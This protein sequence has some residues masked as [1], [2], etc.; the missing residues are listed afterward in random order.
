MRECICGDLFHWCSQCWSHHCCA[1]TQ[2]KVSE[3]FRLDSFAFSFRFLSYFFFLHSFSHECDKFPIC[4]GTLKREKNVS[5]VP[6]LWV[7]LFFH[8]I[9]I[10]INDST[11]RALNTGFSSWNKSITVINCHHSFLSL[12]VK[13]FQHVQNALD[14]AWT[15]W[16]RHEM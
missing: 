15:K 9:I 13:R 14:D 11:D 1:P 7:H 10:G 16:T 5:T 3:E 12:S 8:F 6:A 2:V 4:V